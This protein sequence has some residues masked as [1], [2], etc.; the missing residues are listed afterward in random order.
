MCGVV[1]CSFAKSA[2]TTII[3]EETE[4]KLGSNRAIQ[5]RGFLEGVVSLFIPKSYFARTVPQVHGHV[6]LE[7]KGNGGKCV[8]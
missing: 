2:S 6:E 8:N 7:V 5:N 4:E 1:T 3:S